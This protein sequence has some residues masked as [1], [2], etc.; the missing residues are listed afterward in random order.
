VIR[1]AA[2]GMTSDDVAVGVSSLVGARPLTVQGAVGILLVECS[3]PELD[4]FSRELEAQLP[5]RVDKV[6]LADL[7]AA[8]QRKKGRRHWVA[9]ATSFLHVPE[10]ERLLGD[11]GVPVIALLAEVH[12]ETLH[13]LAQFPPRTRVGVASAEP[14]TA[15]NLEHSI[16]NARLPNIV[17]VGACRAERAALG[18]LAR[19]VDVIVCSTPVA[20]RVQRLVGSTAEVIIDNRVLDKRAIEML[21]AILVRPNGDGAPSTP[22]PAEQHP[23]ARPSGKAPARRP[24]APKPEDGR[25]RVSASLRRT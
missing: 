14:E 15:H 19:R 7:A 20:E 25:M 22:P 16:A 3:P 17:L 12:L 1:A 8:V 21:A 13:R 4:F 9:A 24:S 10:V 18:R 5:V 2:L 6:R 11:S 23:R